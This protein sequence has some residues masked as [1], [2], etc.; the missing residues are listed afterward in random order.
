VIIIRCAW[1]PRYRGY[2]KLISVASWQGRRLEFSDGLCSSCADR[3]R[4]ETFR[5][6]R[7]P[8]PAPPRR[9]ARAAALFVGVPLAAALV[10]LAAPL[11]SPPPQPPMSARVVVPALSALPERA[12]RPPAA[13]PEPNAVA[14]RRA[15]D[16]A[17]ANRECPDN[18]AAVVARAPST[19]TQTIARAP[20]VNRTLTVART[21]GNARWIPATPAAAERSSAIWIPA[22]APRTWA[23][24]RRSAGVMEI[25]TP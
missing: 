9:T 20:S 21:P 24:T 16:G 15:G 22:D 5:R 23:P 25:Q 19:R 18:R 7:A 4:V 8:A 13:R 3:V 17:L 6:D 2:P 10:L 14:P 12:V 11:S 1:H